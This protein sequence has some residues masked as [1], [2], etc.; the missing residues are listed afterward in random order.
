MT[1]DAYVSPRDRLHREFAARATTP[2]AAWRARTWSRA[3]LLTPDADDAAVVTTLTAEWAA[4]RVAHP[5]EPEVTFTPPAPLPA[6]EVVPAAPPY[7]ELVPL[8]HGRYGV[9][10]PSHED[11]VRDEQER[12][13]RRDTAYYGF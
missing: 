3:V 8:R 6:D 10:L 1:S 4:Y 13:A 9:D 5:D 11:R 2:P 7:A 12:L